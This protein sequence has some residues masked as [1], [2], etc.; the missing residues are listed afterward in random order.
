MNIQNQNLW[1]NIEK[2][3]DVLMYALPDIFPTT[4]HDKC[5]STLQFVKKNDTSRWFFCKYLPNRFATYAK[6]DAVELRTFI[7]CRL[8]ETWQNKLR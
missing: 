2:R 4:I 7:V 1:Q 3:I 8:A 6:H 5:R